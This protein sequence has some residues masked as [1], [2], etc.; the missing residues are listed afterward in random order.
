MQL[1]N[2]ELGNVK[3]IIHNVCKTIFN[4]I[5]MMEIYITKLG[6]RIEK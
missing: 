5:D 1:Q 2:K 6:E 3:Y 4:N